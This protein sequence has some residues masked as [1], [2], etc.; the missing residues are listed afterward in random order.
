MATCKDHKTNFVVIGTGS[1][2][3]K[4]QAQDRD[5][6]PGF[7]TLMEGDGHFMLRFKKGCKPIT[8][9]LYS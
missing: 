6:H 8:G 9:I 3:E 5:R 1:G 7:A 2:M 4:N